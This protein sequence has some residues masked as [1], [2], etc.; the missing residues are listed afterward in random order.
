MMPCGACP[1]RRRECVMST[2]RAGC[3][4]YLAPTC[5][6]RFWGPGRCAVLVVSIIEAFG[7]TCDDGDPDERSGV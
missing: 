4:F 6:S 7:A 1:V 5:S 3:H 2:L